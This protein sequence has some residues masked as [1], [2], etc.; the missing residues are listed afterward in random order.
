MTYSE[1]DIAIVGMNC[2]YPGVHSVA[3]FETVLRTGCNILDPKVTPSNGHNHITLNNVYEH[4]AEFDANFFGYSRAEA[5][6]MDP[7]QRVFLTCAWEMFEQSGYNPKQHDARVGLYAGVST[8]FYLLTHLMNNP[9]KLA[10]LGGL[11]IMVGNDK[12]HLTSQLAYRLNITGPCVTVQASCATSLVAVHL[13]CEGL[14]SGQCDMALAGGVTF[15][16]EEQ[17]SYES[18]G[19]GL[20]AEDGLIHTFDAQAS[21]TV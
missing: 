4:M 15:R 1:S 13:A 3:A 18:H 12:D 8:S 5:E 20:Q 7:Q 11:Q 9:D 10:Q 17:R 19:D 21:G 16:M 14:L 6:I 2:R